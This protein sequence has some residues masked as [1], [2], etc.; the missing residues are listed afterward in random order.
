MGGTDDPSNLIELTIEEHAEAHFMLWKQYGKKED[1]VAWAALEGH[2]GKEEATAMSMKIG[3]AKA[4]ANQQRK[5]EENPDYVKWQMRGITKEI[6]SSNGKKTHLNA[7]A[8]ALKP[9][10][11]KKR[12]E[13]LAKIEHQQ[14]EKNSQYGTMWI[15]NGSN[16]KKVSKDT[17]TLPEGYRKGRV[18]K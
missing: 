9:K 8:A 2:I 3:L 6:L 5:R 11:K 10:A 14:G 18:L 17:I 13:T 1:F 16:N 7:S 12:K 15:T 4:R